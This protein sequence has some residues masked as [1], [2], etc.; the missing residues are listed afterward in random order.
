M[1]LAE[2]LGA[3]QAE[4]F[5]RTAWPSAPFLA[6]GPLERLSGLV[7]PKAAFDLPS[8]LRLPAGATYAQVRDGPR[9]PSYA[10]SPEAALAFYRAGVSIYCWEVTLS[11]PRTRRWLAQL[12][13]ELGVSDQLPRFGVFASRA[14]VGAPLHFDSQESF[15]VQL[16]GKKEWTFAPNHNISFPGVNHVAVDPVPAEL[17]PDWKGRTPRTLA[18]A[19]RVVLRPG[20]VLFLPR[21]YWHSTRTVQDSVHLDVMFPLPTWSDV[22]LGRLKAQLD[23]QAHW[24]APAVGAEWMFQMAR[25]LVTQAERLAQSSEV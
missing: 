1:A 8:L 13:S 10:V 15:I 11:R 16:K 17:L 4:R 2:L 3:R 21:G 23:G 6:H 12:R 24:R 20:S 5:L 22:L 25:E 19:R 9:F 18:N 7:D 14:Q